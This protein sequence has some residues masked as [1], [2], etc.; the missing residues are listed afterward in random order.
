MTL[1]GEFVCMHLHNTKIIRLLV[2]CH[3]VCERACARVHV[4]VRVRVRAC[5]RAY[6][7]E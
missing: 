3:S 6:V 7:C 5:A 2:Q 1:N 4:R